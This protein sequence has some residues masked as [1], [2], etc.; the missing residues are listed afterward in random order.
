MIAGIENLCHLNGM[1]VYDHERR[2][3]MAWLKN[4]QEGWQAERDKVRAEEEAKREENFINFEELVRGSIREKMLE[5]Q[6][7]AMVESLPHKQMLEEAQKRKIAALKD[8]SN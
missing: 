3:V 4:N 6:M 2:C 5:N 7:Q 8:K 1:Q